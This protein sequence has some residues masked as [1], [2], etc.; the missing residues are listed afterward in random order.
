MY[1]F[2]T[3]ELSNAVRGHVNEGFNYKTR[4]DAMGQNNVKLPKKTEPFTTGA[5]SW[6]A[7]VHI[8]IIQYIS[9]TV[10]K[11]D[12]YRCIRSNRCGLGFYAERQIIFGTVLYSVH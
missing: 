1:I 9:Y 3:L 7:F 6:L 2:L 11:P 5:G 12:V 10:Q 4:N 8:Y